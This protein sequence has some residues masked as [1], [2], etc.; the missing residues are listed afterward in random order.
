MPACAIEVSC[1]GAATTAST[2]PAIAAL[3]AAAQNA[4]EARP[5]IGLT[6][7][8]RQRSGFRLRAGQ[9]IDVCQAGFDAARLGMTL[10]QGRIADHQRLASR[11][12]GGI[13][14]RL[15]RDLRP[16]AGRIA[17][18]NRD[19]DLGQT[20]LTPSWPGL[21]RRIHVFLALQSKRRMAGIEPGHDVERSAFYSHGISEAWITSGTPSLPTERMARS[22]SFKPNLCV[23]ISSS[24]KRF[25]AI[26]S[27]ASSQAL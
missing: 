9:D 7:P 2:S 12:D 21:S 18:G 1:C 11:P 10:K 6:T 25:D 23:V 17:D 19:L 14:R 8:K 13:E 20:S 26:C 3:T 24:G 16:D 22:T 15:Q 5:L 27:S 4:I